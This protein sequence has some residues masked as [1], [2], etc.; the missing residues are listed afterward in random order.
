MGSG[1]PIPVSVLTGFLGAGKTTL[2]NRLLKDPALADTAVI[3]NEFGE[4]AIDHLLVEQSSDGIIQ[5]S[6]GCLCCTVRGELVDTLADLVDRLQTGRI[7]RLARV[8]VETTGLADPAPVLQSIMAHPALIQAFR[9]DGVI[10]LVD[11]VNGNATLDAH[12]EAVKQAAVADRIVLSKADLVVDP[13]ELEMLR[14]RLRQINPGAELLDAGDT[15][16]GVAALFDCGLYNPATKSADVRRWLGEEAAHDHHHHDHDHHDGH[17]HEHGHDH[18]HRHDSRVR[19]YS[20]VHDGPVPFSAIEMFLDLLRSTH[21]E[22]LLRMKGVIELRE[23]PSRPLVIHGV[24]K[25]L[26]PPVQLPS[27]PDGQRGTRLVLITLD[28]PEDYI[29]RLF[30]AFTNRPSIDTPDRAALENNPLAIAGR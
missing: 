17:D 10:T 20:L 12:V 8:I 1:F 30:A 19:S 9:L 18:G 29:R 22:R 27:W 15:G 26:H 13:N 3:I 23:D 2:L 24:Q 4:V 16:T 21:G 25:I 5:L 14:A 28:M 11:A 7:A 6:D